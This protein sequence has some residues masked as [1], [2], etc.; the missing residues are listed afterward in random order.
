[1]FLMRIFREIPSSTRQDTGENTCI[2]PQ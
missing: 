2:M 1:M